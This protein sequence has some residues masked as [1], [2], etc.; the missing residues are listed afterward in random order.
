VGSAGSALIC[1]FCTGTLLASVAGA[2]NSRFLTAASGQFGMTSR[3]WDTT[4]VPVLTTKITKAY[5]GNFAAR[6]SC[7]FVT[8]V[9][10][11]L[12]RHALDAIADAGLSLLLD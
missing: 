9:V 4:P 11:E 6:P 8:S 7:Y 2:A 10:D 5:E 1:R 3:N 12:D